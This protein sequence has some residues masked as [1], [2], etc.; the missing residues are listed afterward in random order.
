MTFDRPSHPPSLPPTALDATEPH[1]SSRW[2]GTILVAGA[3]AIVTSMLMGAHREPSPA[4]TTAGVSQPLVAPS[5]VTGNPEQPPSEANA[6][7]VEQF[8]Q[9]DEV[10]I[11]GD[12]A[13]K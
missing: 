11:T 2:V 1:G 3:A 12:E 9:L 13:P 8:V 7:I 10:V 4:P 6:P 5:C